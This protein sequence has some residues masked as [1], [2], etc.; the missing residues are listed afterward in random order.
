[1]LTGYL[2][3]QE[4]FEESLRK[5]NETM[6]ER[7]YGPGKDRLDRFKLNDKSFAGPVIMGIGG[8]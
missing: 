1:V 3:D 8:K 7:L 5:N 2:E 4:I 6:A